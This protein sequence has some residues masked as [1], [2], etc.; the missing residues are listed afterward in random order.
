MRRKFWSQTSD[1]IDKWSSRGGKSQSRERNKKEDQ[2]RRR[3]R[4]K[5]VHKAN[6]EVT[7]LK[8]PRVRTT[9]GR[10]TVEKCT[11]LW[12][13]AH[14]EVKT[15]KAQHSQSTF[16]S[17]DVEKGLWREA[18]CK[19]K[20]CKVHHVWNTCGRKL[21]CWK[22]AWHCGTKQVMKPKLEK[23]KKHVWTTF[24]GCDVERMHAVVARS[25]FAFRCQKL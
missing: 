15:Y 11:R 23:H 8:T 24:G 13:E 17:W 1:N 2:R 16:G 20:M 14:F 7:M 19:V 4:R 6:F 3:V 9:V 10:G 21:R 5:N 12:R 18:H 25:T 22:S